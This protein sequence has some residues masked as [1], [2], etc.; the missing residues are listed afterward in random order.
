MTAAL[1]SNLEKYNDPTVVAAY[2]AM[3][4]L[5]PCEKVLF[6]R[7]LIPGM[8][9]LDIGVG[10]GRTTPYLS[11]VAGRYVGVDY[12]IAMVDACR[13]RFPNVEFRHCDATDMSQFSDG[14]FDAVVFSFNGIDS[15]RT[16]NG[17]A[18]CLR[19]IA[20]V[21]KSSGKFVFSSHNAKALGIWP[22]LHTA[23]GFQ[24]PWR[25]YLAGSKTMR[26]ALRALTSTTYF[27]GEGYIHDP[28]HG[29]LA[30]YTSTPATMAPQLEE[31]GLE[32]IE[33]VGGHYPEVRSPHLTPWYYYACRKAA[34]SV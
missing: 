3:G 25:M 21:Q 17:R 23:R 20:R 31:A 2:A 32:I 12:S 15:I 8:A 33:V 24:V 5:Q 1:D 26:I 13:E 29:G 19:E 6:D 22:Q 9:I 27:A 14:E 34:G 18:Q 30:T 16:D 28:V 4:D 11:Q 7:H 10:G